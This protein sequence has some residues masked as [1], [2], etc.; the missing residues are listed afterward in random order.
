MPNFILRDDALIHLQLCP[1][2]LT[3]S[4]ADCRI[5]I[6]TIKEKWE[7]HLAI[8]KIGISTMDYLHD[9]YEP[10]H[11]SDDTLFIAS[12]YL[13]NE[14]LIKEILQLKP[15][16]SL[17]FG[18]QIIA[19]YQLAAHKIETKANLICVK[20]PWDLFSQNAVVLEEDFTWI[21]KGRTSQCLD[22]HSKIIGDPN[23]LFIEEGAIVNASI[24]NTTTGSIYIG[25]EAEVMENTVIR[26]GFALCEHAGTKLS[27]K[28]YGATTIGPY[29]KIG[30]EVNNSILF[31]YSNKG[32]DGF[33]GNSVIGEW[34][35]LGADT[36][37][38]NLKNN[39]SE[40]KSYSYAAKGEV[41]TGLQFCG[42]MMGDHSKSSINT[43]FNTG[44]VCGVSANIFHSGF[45][46]KFIRSFSWGDQRFDFE[47]ALEVA[48]RMM[49]RRGKVL[50]KEAI[51]V[52]Q[53]LYTQSV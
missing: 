48:R 7:S 38:S 15:N 53:H 9:L 29:C 37:N 10:L 32:H 6:T 43:M 21:T 28:V 16:E 13:P 27:T 50:T 18:E 12:H 49:E 36:N 41:K 2:T 11:I 22:I 34:C 39:Y 40:V 31:G 47:K 24:F 33:L 46:P 8:S 52:L 14:Q 17:V 45:P 1:L 35:N 42:L 5:G 30:G 20:H 19:S 4:I 3:R 25:K 44:T 23:R 26:G 51:S